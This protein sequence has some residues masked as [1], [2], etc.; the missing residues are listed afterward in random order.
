[1]AHTARS[2]TV[3]PVTIEKPVM[4]ATLQ[5]DATLTDLF[6]DNV[7]SSPLQD[8]I[9]KRARAIRKRLT[10]NEK[11]L[12]DQKHTKLN[13]D[14]LEAVS[15]I[16]HL[17]FALKELDEILKQ[18]SAVE[19]SEQDR[20]EQLVQKLE[21]DK[22]EQIS[23]I[24]RETEDNANIF[25]TNVLTLQT[26]LNSFDVRTANPL[27]VNAEEIDALIAFKNAVF[28]TVDSTQD[29]EKL[30]LTTTNTTALLKNYFE[31][32]ETVLFTDNITFAQLFDIVDRI[33]NP[34]APIKFTNEVSEETVADPVVVV[35]PDVAFVPVPAGSINF[36]NPS[37]VLGKFILDSLL[38]SENVGYDEM[39]K[40]KY[41]F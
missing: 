26:I 10:K 36:I 5:K 4:V 37:E 39:M 19:N 31:K 12:A 23:A 9:H 17:S 41:Y 20:V 2:S 1:M 15:H 24:K 27:Y 14:Q 11:Y 33:S 7:T 28:P 13:K 3:N 22:Q 29:F 40:R 35:V 32:S 25:F 30:N 18:V 8:L 21:A 16:P 6:S 38:W 34:P